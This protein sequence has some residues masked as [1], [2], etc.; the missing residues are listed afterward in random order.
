MKMMMR[1]LQCLLA[2]SFLAAST[3]GAAVE[4][5]STTTLAQGPVKKRVVNDSGIKGEMKRDLHEWEGGGHWHEEDLEDLQNYYYIH[6]V[7]DGESLSMSFPT[8]PPLHD[9][10]Y[11]YKGKGK[12]KGKGGSYKGK[13]MKSSKK[14][15]K[16][17]KSKKMGKKSHYDGY[18]YGYEHEHDGWYGHEHEHEGGHNP[19]YYEHGW[20]FWEPSGKGKGM[21]SK[22][23]GMGM[24]KGKGE[25]KGKGKGKGKGYPGGPMHP[26]V[27]PAMHTS[28]PSLPGKCSI[29]LLAV[30]LL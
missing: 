15:K 2:A 12:G 27:A 5:L 8:A 3:A 28:S 26:T 7:E 30:W 10:Y 22:S 9:D 6:Y 23:M 25:G 16:H 24:G 4:Q 1:S 13:M 19:Y 18:W 21:T 11:Y 17:Q 20:D 14:G 29:L